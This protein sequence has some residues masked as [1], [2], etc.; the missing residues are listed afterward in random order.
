MTKKNAWIYALPTKP[1]ATFSNK[2]KTEL[3]QIS[4][5]NQDFL[6]SRVSGTNVFLFFWFPIFWADSSYFLNVR[7]YKSDLPLGVLDVDLA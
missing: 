5:R 4:L 3:S 1:F 7:K 2:T 6:T